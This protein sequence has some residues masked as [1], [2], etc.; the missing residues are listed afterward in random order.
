MKMRRCKE[1]GEEKQYMGTGV[2]NE[3]EREWRRV[4][5]V[6]ERGRKRCE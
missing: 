4:G 1:G 2:R 6:K 5:K 3:C